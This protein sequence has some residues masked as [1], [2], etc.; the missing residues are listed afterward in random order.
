VPDVLTHKVVAHGMHDMTFLQ[1]A[2]PVEQVGHH[3][4]NRGLPGSRRPGEAHMQVRP[5]RGEPEPLSGPVDQQ[6]RTDFFHLLLHRDEPDQLA[7]QRDEQVIDA[8]CPPFTG[9]G[10]NG[11]RLER[12]V[13]PQCHSVQ[14]DRHSRS[15]PWC[16][17]PVFNAE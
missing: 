9:E 16:V 12:L 1:V 8:C 13:P 5:S 4:R 17:R 2:K 10:D 3:Q 11:I 14:H 7:V 6:Q 15:L